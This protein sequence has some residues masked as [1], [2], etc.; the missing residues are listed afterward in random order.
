M[1]RGLT[2][3]GLGAIANDEQYL[4]LASRYGFQ[5]VD[6]D[7]TGLI[8][9]LGLDGTKARLSELGLS[10]GS[11]G[12]S[13]DW[14]TTEENFRTSLTALPAQ[15][16]A[17]AA[18]G[19]TRCCTYVLPSVDEPAAQFTV[20][21]TKRLRL[22]AQILGGYGIRLGLEFVGPHHL[23]T[24]WAN[25]FLWTAEDT[26][27]WIE[28]IGEPNVGLLFDAYHWY[29]T[30]MTL[31]D[32]GRLRADQ[33]VHVHI[34][35]AKDVP[36][37]EALDNDRV[38]PGEGVI[39]LVGFLKALHAIGYN[40]PVAQEILMPAPPTDSPEALAER[41]RQGF[42]RVFGAAGL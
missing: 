35:D 17:A 3:A 41:S 25:P 23:R 28:A 11:I 20:S 42:D 19:V 4:E 37:A 30:G 22:C 6:L 14:R 34:N 39:D 29:T 9:Q 32:I 16:A 26:L 40:G 7:P 12:L 18:L 24:R 27:A 21:A 5:T 13:V 10:I 1:L 2:P 38:Y 36:V 8:G 31:E 33:I 15:A